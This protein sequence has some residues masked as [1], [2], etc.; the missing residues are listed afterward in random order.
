MRAR[1]RRLAAPVVALAVVVVATCGA[2]SDGHGT[3][4]AFCKQIKVTPGLDQ[5]LSGFRTDDPKTLKTKLDTAT[6][7][8]DKLK[9]AAPST[10]HGDV[11]TVVALVHDVADAVE[12]GSTDSTAL[13]TRLR[14]AVAE[15]PEATGAAQRMAVYTHTE[16]GID[17]NPSSS[18]SGSTAPTTSTTTTTPG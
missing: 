9:K 1:P 10:I 8:F 13:D 15:H 11:D 12:N 7:A 17:L 5:V 3:Q 18:T 2:C 14:K 4:E 16:C 6:K